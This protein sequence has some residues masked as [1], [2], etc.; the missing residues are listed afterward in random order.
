MNKLLPKLWILFI[1]ALLV[2][3][4]F[5]LQPNVKNNSSEAG[6]SADTSSDPITL[7]ASDDLRE[8]VLESIDEKEVIALAKELIKI[9]SFTTEESDCAK[10]LAKFME[11]RGMEVELQEVEE[12]RLQVVGR[13]RG[14]GGGQSLMLNGHI[15][16][17]QLTI[18]WKKDPWIPTIEDGRLYGAGIFNMKGGVTAMVMAADAIKKA[19]IELKGDLIVAAVVGELQG[20]VGTVHL[21]EKG[22][23][24]DMAVVTE[25]YGAHN[26]ITTHGG[27]M[28]LAINTI[29]L[30]Q[31]I[32]RKEKGIDALEKMV[33][34]I[35][36]LNKMKFSREK[37]SLELPGL[38]RL[39]VG[40][41]ICGRG[42]EHELRGPAF[43]PDFCTILVDIRFHSG[44]TPES[45]IKDIN[46]ALEELRAEDPELKYEIEFPADP[47]WKVDQTPMYPI[48]IPKDTF[49]IQSVIKNHK[50]VTGEDMKKIGSILPLSY[51]GNDTSHLWHAGIPCCL[52]GPS[53][54][55]SP[56]QYILIDEML[57]CTRVLALT[58]L[59]V[60]NRIK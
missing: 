47:K 20:G 43:V 37:P 14:T 38:P 13:I 50:Q 29:G 35:D 21:L 31:H 51:A 5:L 34:V 39:L 55:S 2:G 17:D 48:N 40:S 9:P 6:I 18:G 46:N 4:S 56:E 16:I 3:G 19:G 27:V 24:A 59:D 45:I 30:S 49:I 36:A 60:C 52:Y 32:S 11:E 8:K 54:G 15:D 1:L 28:E 53:G 44:M 41:M 23:K 25:P 10:F 22:I 57:I 7:P 58:A 12:G 42:Y 33:K 26:I